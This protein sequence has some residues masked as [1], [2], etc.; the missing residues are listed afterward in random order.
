LSGPAGEMR[1]PLFAVTVLLIVLVPLSR[2]P[3]LTV[4]GPL[5]VPTLS[6][7]PLLLIVTGPA[8][9]PV[10]SRVAPAM[11]TG[12]PVRLPE[13]VKLPALTVVRSGVSARTGQCKVSCARLG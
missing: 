12:E 9:V 3:L 8:I 2:P 5:N 7:T 13:T 10:P 4:T 1:E 11:L 6:T